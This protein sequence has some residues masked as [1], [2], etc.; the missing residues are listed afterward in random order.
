MIDQSAVSRN[1]VFGFLMAALLASAVST[2]SEAESDKLEA[3]KPRSIGPAAMSGRVTT[4]DVDPRDPDLIYAG[5]ASGGLWRSRNQGTTWEP[6]FD[7]QDSASIGAVA[8]DPLNSDVIWVATGEA[9]PRNSQSVGTGIYKSI[10]G[11]RTWTHLGLEKSE[12]LHRVIIH[13]R[14]TGTVYVCATGPTWSDGEQ[15]GVYKTADAGQSWQKVLYINESTGCGDL[16]M[17]PVNPDK[18]MA[19]MWDHRRTPWDFRSGGPGSGL[20]VSYDGGA[21]WTRRTHQDGLPEGDLG[22]I[23]LAI[24]KS[25]PDIAYALVEAKKSALYRSEDGGHNWEMVNDSRGIANRPF[26]YCDIRVD[27]GNENRVFN[28]FSSVTVSQDGGRNFEDLVGFSSAHSDHHAFWIDPNNPRYM[29]DGNDGGL[30]I[31]RDGGKSW[32]FAENIP[33]G[34]FYHNT[35]DGQ[36]PYNVYGGLQ[37]N[38]SFMG[39]S[40]VW[41][42]GVGGGGILNSHWRMISF[43]D[44]F[45]V[46]P[47]RGNPR[48]AYSMSQGGSLYKVDLLTGTSKSIRPPDPEGE[49]LRFNWNAGIAADP[50]DEGTIYYGS[51]YLHRSRDR[52]ESWETISGD[53]TTNDLEKQKQLE[54]GGLTYDVTGAENHTTI[55]AVAPSPVKKGVIWVGSD[56]GNVQ[57]TRD[58]GESWTNLVGNIPGVPEATWVPHIEASKFQE[59]GAFVV[60]D[61]HR[62]GN[63]TP[64]A[65]KT[66]DYGQTWTSLASDDLR[67]FVYVIEQD[68]TV[69]DLLF[70]GTEF[71]LYYSLDG[72][73]S[74]SRWQH[75]YPTVPTRDLAIH[76]TQP[77]LVIGTFG[78][79]IFIMDDIT[80]LREM[81]RQGRGILDRPLHLF[82]VAA[83]IQ[84]ETGAPP[85]ELTP[86]DAAFRGENRPSGAIISYVFNAPEEEAVPADAEVTN[87][88]NGNGAPPAQGRRR[89]QRGQRR[90]GP[91]GEEGDEDGKKGVKIEILDANDKVIQTLTGPMEPGLNRVVW[92]LDRERVS[93]PSRRQRPDFFGRGGVPVV[94]GSYTVRA[95]FGELQSSEQIR[96]L[97]DPRTDIPQADRQAKSDMIEALNGHI[98]TLNA[99]FKRLE[100]AEADMERVDQMAEGASGGKI[101]AFRQESR[102]AGERLKELTAKILPEPVQGIRRDR[103]T[104]AGKVSRAS[105]Y[106][107]SS[108]DAPNDTERKAMA[109][110]ERAVKAFAAEVEAFFDK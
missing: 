50:F 7:D 8:V 93:L 85:G 95:S 31:S 58:G 79:A 54:S 22:R 83:A 90:G 70:L 9:N 98:E 80:P 1:L 3:L 87:D 53:L 57:L 49:L 29:I 78:R 69:E 55:I 33:L 66:S 72:G 27:P 77:D 10:D 81:A 106:L 13:P 96:V 15:R 109:Q 73:Q 60:F 76:P 32:R 24:A 28:I 52:G 17:D 21:S 18:L 40:Q 65:F 23:G 71:H 30:T 42:R 19:A 36:T 14:N 100:K 63:W 101:E 107:Q 88:A 104:V 5:S 43:G 45:D 64:Y 75:G 12:H 74:W 99:A 41:E 48:I 68:P 20:H 108:W 38:G 97:A 47:D 92:G 35:L 89:A 11:G 61:D 94:P 16:V 51:Q 46:V 82:E 62:R 91:G 4:I 34:Q 37:D 110:A 2:A 6:I 44:G 103:D 102:K 39:P 59:G 56:D 84:A 26:Y 86:G 105:S 25:R 67:G